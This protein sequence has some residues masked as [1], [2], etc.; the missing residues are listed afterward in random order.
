MSRLHG[1]LLQVPGL[2]EAHSQ[3]PELVCE[4]WCNGVMTYHFG[5]LLTSQ[6]LIFYFSHKMLIFGGVQNAGNEGAA[7]ILDFDLFH[8]IDPN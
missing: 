7:K 5:N 2:E 3:E 1:L 6:T 4:F 8:K